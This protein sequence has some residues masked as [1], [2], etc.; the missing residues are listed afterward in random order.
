MNE[1]HLNKQNSSGQRLLLHSFIYSFRGHDTRGEVRGKRRTHRPPPLSTL[2]VQGIKLRPS[3][4][5]ASAFAC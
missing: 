4:L 2:W 3:D 5:V 1:A